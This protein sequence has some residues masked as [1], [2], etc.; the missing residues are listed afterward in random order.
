MVHELEE[1]ADGSVIPQPVLHGC[2]QLVKA[3]GY[4]FALE[5]AEVYEDE[6]ME[7]LHEAIRHFPEADLTRTVDPDRLAFSSQTVQELLQAHHLQVKVLKS[8]GIDP[9]LEYKQH[10]VNTV[11]QN[12]QP[13]SKKCVIC[14]E[15]FFNAQKLREHITLKHGH[16]T[17]HICKT[18]KK[19]F[20]TSKSL[21]LH[22]QLHKK[23]GKKFACRQCGNRYQSD[24]RLQQ[25]LREHFGGPEFMCSMCNKVF[26]QKKSVKDH[27]RICPK[28]PQPAERSKC[29]LC[30]KTYSA[31]KDTRRHF[32]TAHPQYNIDEFL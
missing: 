2:L 15:I 13:Q 23:S 6:E 16:K 12:I 31:K 11:L 21:G 3:S 4:D 9:C 24:A 30:D 19:C 25:H 5:K 18:C 29:P 32:K 26:A 14:K 17:K 20:G 1:K 28:N 22:Q 7:P 27:E 10:E 8:M